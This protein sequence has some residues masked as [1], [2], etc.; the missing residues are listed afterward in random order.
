MLWVYGHQK[1]FVYS[2]EILMTKVDPR[3]LRVN[4][5]AA[6]LLISIFDLL[7]IVWRKYFLY[8]CICKMD[9]SQ[10]IMIFICHNRNILSSFGFQRMKNTDNQFLMTKVTPVKELIKLLQLSCWD[11]IN[12]W[13]HSIIVFSVRNISGTGL[14]IASRINPEHIWDWSS[15]GKM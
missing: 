10:I 9:I 11:L 7:N 3:A 13:R 4:P 8:T 2:C 15:M 5:G 1:S 14:G 6:E 12:W